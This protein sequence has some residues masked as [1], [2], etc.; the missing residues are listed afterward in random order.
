MEDYLDK[1]LDSKDKVLGEIY[2][3][4]NTR[5]GKKYIGQTV[6]HRLNHGK[7]R[8]FGYKRRFACHVSEALCDTKVGQCSGISNA[9][10]THGQESFQV[11]LLMR[12]PLEDLDANEQQAIAYH[13]TLYPTGYNLARGGNLKYRVTE[14]VERVTIR[15]QRVKSYAKREDT[16]VLIGQRLKEYHNEHPEEAQKTF[17]RNKD[18]RLPLKIRALPLNS[19]IDESNLEQHLVRRCSKGK[20]YYVAKISGKLFTFQSKYDDETKS[21]ERAI[22]FLKRASYECGLQRLQIAGSP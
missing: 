3:I 14:D 10:R 1:I 11:S 8:P 7:Y 19:I 12:C 4:V 20:P 9:I 18:R 21:K 17:E 5:D 2:E 13:K 15:E 6:T 16:K 22:D